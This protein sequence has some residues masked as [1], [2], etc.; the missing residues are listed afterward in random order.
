MRRILLGLLLAAA[1]ATLLAQNPTSIVQLGPSTAV[2]TT[3]PVSG[4]VTVTQGTA[5][6]LKVD[7]S[8]T[9]A[10]ATAIKVDGSAAIQPV[11][12]TFWQ[13]MQ[14]VSGTFFQGTQPVSI[15]SGQIVDGGDTTLGSKADAKSTATDTTAITVMQVL[16]EISAMEQAPASRAV[17]N[18]GTFAVT[19][20][21][22]TNLHAVLDTTSTTAV[23]Q[24]TGTNLHAVLDTTSTTA[25]TQATAANLNATVVF[26]NADPCLGNAKSYASF[27]QTTTTQILGA[28]GS[29]KRYYIC[30]VNLVT[31]GAQNVGFI[32]STTAGNA[33]ATSP[34]G[35]DGFGGTTTG[36]WN[37]AANGGLTYGNGGF[38]LGQTHNTNAAL[39][40]YQSSTGQ[41]SGGL[42][43]VTQ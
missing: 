39:C 18:A 11:S 27:N 23:T 16:K 38:A 32:D 10:N 37:F 31:G 5:A 12:G 9:G 33:C 30:A 15:A 8:G 41:V 4:S 13:A 42:S 14:P 29:S 20:A 6:N 21:T 25:A 43:Y 34:A 3:M 19:Q 1:G 35:S 2:T 36:T 22:G 28:S 7:L 26:P 40:L 17:T 24:A